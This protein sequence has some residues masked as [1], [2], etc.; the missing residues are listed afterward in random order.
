MVKKYKKKPVVVNAIRFTTESLDDVVKFIM[1]GGGNY[2]LDCPDKNTIPILEIDTLEGRMV[3]GLGDYIIQGIA[4]E[5]YLCKSDIFEQ[6]YEEV[7][8]YTIPT[9]EERFVKL[10]GVCNDLP[11]IISA[12]QFKLGNGINVCEFLKKCRGIIGV[13]NEGDVICIENLNH[14]ILKCRRGFIVAKNPYSGCIIDVF[15][16]ETFYKLYE[17]EEG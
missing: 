17:K 11:T 8:D 5:F 7:M 9:G 10:R 4:G 14:T 2:Y 13:W 1:E 15:D 16:F 12:V 6:T 3:C